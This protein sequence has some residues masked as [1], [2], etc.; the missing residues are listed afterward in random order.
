[1]RAAERSIDDGAAAS[2]LERWVGATAA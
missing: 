2:V 1:V